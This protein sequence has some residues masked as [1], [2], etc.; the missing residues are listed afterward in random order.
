MLGPQLAPGTPLQFGL[1]GVCKYGALQLSGDAHQVPLV[2]CSNC[3]ISR[4]INEAVTTLM[5]QQ[6]DLNQISLCISH[7]TH[8][9]FSI[10]FN[11]H[12]SFLFDAVQLWAGA[13]MLTL[14]QGN[15][16]IFVVDSLEQIRTVMHSI[17][18]FHGPSHIKRHQNGCGGTVRASLDLVSLGCCPE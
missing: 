14:S 3:Q 9:S 15:C 5:E 13:D 17:V 1:S 2:T 12:S 6:M 8:L 18:D 10:V 7:P 4:Q 11:L 16:D